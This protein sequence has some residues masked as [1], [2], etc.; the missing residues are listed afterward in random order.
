MKPKWGCRTPGTNIP[1]VSEDIARKYA[2]Y[3]L[4]CRGISKLI[5]LKENKN[6]EKMGVN[7]FSHYHISRLYK[8]DKTKEY[9]ERNISGF[10]GFYDTGSEEKIMA[11]FPLNFIYRMFIFP[12]EKKI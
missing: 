1:I 11:P 7:L 8:M 10:A 5:F 9:W 6:L 2:D 12:I 4:A 3:F